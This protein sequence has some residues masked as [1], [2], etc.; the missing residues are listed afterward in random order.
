MHRRALCRIAPRMFKIVKL[1]GQALR[2]RVDRQNRYVFPI[3]TKNLLDVDT[4]TLVKFNESLPFN[5]VTGLPF[6]VFWPKEET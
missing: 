3:A 6:D 5:L 1:S 2:F 4:Q